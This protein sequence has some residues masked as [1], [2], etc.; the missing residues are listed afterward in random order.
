MVCPWLPAAKKP[1]D[2]K[3]KRR[4]IGL[5]FKVAI[6]LVMLNNFY[7]FDNVVR[8]QFKGGAI[9]NALTEVLGK[10]VMKR[11]GRRMEMEMKRLHIEH[12][13][14]VSYVDDITEVM[15]AF[16]V[17]VRFVQGRLEKREEWEREDEEKGTPGD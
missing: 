8:K 17:G 11:Q 12:E 16:D 3:I 2:V 14:F 9:G 5:M 10:L 6:K 7:S 13:L 1:T 15:V 4:M